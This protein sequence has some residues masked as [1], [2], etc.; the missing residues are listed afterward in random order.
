MSTGRLKLSDEHWD[1]IRG[2]RTRLQIDFFEPVESL[3]GTVEF[4]L[5]PPLRW[6]LALNRVL[7]SIGNHAHSPWFGVDR[8]P[9]HRHSNLESLESIFDLLKRHCPTVLIAGIF[10]FFNHS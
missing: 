10:P 9:L 6:S 3:G 7:G 5:A 1:R 8:I 2:S 4:H